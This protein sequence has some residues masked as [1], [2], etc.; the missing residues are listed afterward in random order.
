[1]LLLLTFCRA[2][3]K[4][5]KKWFRPE[6]IFKGRPYQVIKPP[7]SAKDVK[8]RELGD[9]YFCS[10]L[11]SIAEHPHRLERI[12]I[13]KSVQKNGCYCV[14]LNVMGV[15][16]EVILDDNFP[17]NSWKD[18]C[19]TSSTVDELWV[20]LAEKAFAKICGGYANL[21]SGNA[22]EAMAMITGAPCTYF[23][24]A[25]QTNQ[26]IFDII[27]DAQ[28]NGFVT[29]TSTISKQ[30]LAKLHNT[31]VQKSIQGLVG[32]H[33]YS[34]LG[35][36]ELVKVGQNYA[37]ATQQDQGKEHTIKLINLRNPWA[38]EEYTGRW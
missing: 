14:A 27:E 24:F 15:W 11:A 34:L 9:C 10:A 13:S 20:L 4:N 31:T 29:S 28:E 25:A 2:A 16:E 5:S 17:C 22:F 6:V 35:Y 36:K 12:F 19:F 33:A 21:W 18:P 30:A 26:G 38:H 8:Q 37:L 1:M 32:G 23:P 3:W 7:L